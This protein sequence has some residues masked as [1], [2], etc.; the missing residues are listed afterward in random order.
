MRWVAFAVLVL[1]LIPITL[2][3]SWAEAQADAD[4]AAELANLTE[5]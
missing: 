5:K 3:A 4:R 1:L 2:Y